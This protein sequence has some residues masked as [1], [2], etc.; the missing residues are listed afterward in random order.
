MV[1]AAVTAKVRSSVALDRICCRC[2]S[3]FL[4]RSARLVSLCTVTVCGSIVIPRLVLRQDG[5]KTGAAHVSRKRQMKFSGLKN[6][7]RCGTPSPSVFCKFFHL[8][9]P[10][11]RSGVGSFLGI[12]H[13]PS[14]SGR[15][16]LSDGVRILWR[17][18]VAGSR[19][20]I[21]ACNL[22]RWKFDG[23]SF[24]L[25]ASSWTCVWCRGLSK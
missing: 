23:P 8:N 18:C 24:P 3:V 12:I 7:Q 9:C 5:K 10:A 20:A 17:R 13:Q 14:V 1:A 11:G 19:H 25:L 6:A 21:L 15:F 22:G 2:A 4:F 16:L